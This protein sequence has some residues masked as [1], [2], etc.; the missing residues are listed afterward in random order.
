MWVDTTDKRYDKIIIGF[1][2]LRTHR[3]SAN[4]SIEL[5]LPT[6]KAAIVSSITLLRIQRNDFRI[7]VSYSTAQRQKEN[8]FIFVIIILE[9]HLVQTVSQV[10]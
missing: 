6:Y 3:R 8:S 10:L 2:D 4:H 1:H 7:T 9:V 5:I